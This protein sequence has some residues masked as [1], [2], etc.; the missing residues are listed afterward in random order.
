MIKRE[1]EWFYNERKQSNIINDLKREDFVYRIFSLKW[2]LD[3]LQNKKIALMNFAKWDDPFENFLF[4]AKAKNKN[5]V[6]VD[7]AK[8]REY[9]YGQSWCLVEETDAIWRIYSND[10]TSVKVKANVGRLFDSL[11]GD[12]ESTCVHLYFGKVF[13]EKL[14][15]T[16]TLMKNRLKIHKS[17][18]HDTSGSGIIDYF[19]IKRPEFEHEHEARIIYN[20]SSDDPIRAKN[21]NNEMIKFDIEPNKIFEKLTLDPRLN[22]KEFKNIELQIRSIGYTGEIEKSSLYDPPSFIVTLDI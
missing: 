8:L 11:Y 9:V 4:K 7:F 3:L 12:G 22:N 20:S 18:F 17:L 10:K 21:G 16:E 14:Q 2:F 5:G 19:L 15:N 1:D 13:Y 6:D